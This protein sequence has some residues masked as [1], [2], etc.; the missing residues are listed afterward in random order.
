ML[1]FKRISIIIIVLIILLLFAIFVNGISHNWFL[2]TGTGYLNTEDYTEMILEYKGLFSPVIREINIIKD[3]ITYKPLINEDKLV[4]GN[5]NLIELN[6]FKIKEKSLLI[7][8][9]KG[10]IKEL[11]E[12]F[13]I[14]IKYSLLGKDYTHIKK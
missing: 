8:L 3:N 9:D 1:N 14:E 12:P 5:I 6:N 2:I 11:K 13:I 4:R 7:A 10:E